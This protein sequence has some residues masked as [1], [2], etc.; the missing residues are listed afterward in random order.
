M[1]KI[2]ELRFYRSGEVV[3]DIGI[4]YLNNIVDEMSKKGYK[5]K[6]ELSS[7]MFKIKGFKEEDFIRF[8]TIDKLDYSYFPYLRNSPKYGSNAQSVENFHSNFKK[9]I[10]IVAGINMKE[11]S[12]QEKVL[13]EYQV[14]ENIC[15]ICHNNLATDNDITHKTTSKPRV[16]SK[17]NYSF[18]GA[19]NNMFSNYGNGNESVCFEC[20]FLNLMYLLYVNTKQPRF[21]IYTEDLNL[22]NFLNYKMALEFKNLNQKS[23]YK[24]LSKHMNKRLRTYKI[25]ID[26]NK[27]IILNLT[28][29]IEVQNIERIIKYYD[30]IDRFNFSKEPSKRKEICKSYVISKNI[31]SLENVLI[32]NLIYIDEGEGK[33]LNKTK[34]LINVQAY[35]EL[36]KMNDKGSGSM[37]CKSKGNAF[38]ELG[39]SLSGKIPEE[40]KKTIMF[41][42]NQMMKSDDRTGLFQILVHLIS[43]NELRIPNKFSYIIMK[44]SSNEIHYQIGRFME[45]FLS[46]KNTEEGK[47]ND[48]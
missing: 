31:S 44:S 20:E 27:G 6:G 2:K 7:N 40:N 48:K 46:S 34:T 43:V 17:Y 38:E 39:V 26:T 13:E 16:N 35:L 28:N 19:E 3:R 10:Y 29:V 24:R 47:V 22:M 32:N 15:S 1:S 23:F 8:I 5:V 11:L 33:G 14:S 9:L 30:I 37:E 18:M 45:G 41:K 4:I 36:L 12:E 42:I 21:I 25:S